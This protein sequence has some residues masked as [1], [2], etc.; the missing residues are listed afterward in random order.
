MRNETVAVVLVV[1]IVLAFLAGLGSSTVLLGGTSN[2]TTSTQCST[3]ATSQVRLQVVNSTSGKPVASASV[4]G[5]VDYGD[6]SGSYTSITL[7]TA[8]TNATGFAF[9]GPEIGTYHLTVQAHGNY[10]VDASTRPFVVTCVTLSV[11]SGETTI[12][13]SQEF[14]FTC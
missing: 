13:Y 12:K 3:I 1:V 8:L 14:L 4:Y 9:F 5:E 7:D 11:P 10:F 6:C 2:S